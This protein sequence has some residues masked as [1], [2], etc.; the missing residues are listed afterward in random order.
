MQLQLVKTRGSTYL[1]R[2]KHRFPVKNADMTHYAFNI[3]RKAYP[4][5][6][7][8]CSS[9][10]GRARSQFFK[11]KR[12]GCGWESRVYEQSPVALALPP[13]RLK[14][15]VQIFNGIGVCSE[16][17]SLRSLLCQGRCYSRHFPLLE[18]QKNL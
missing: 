16:A 4:W 10:F 1:T 5:S 7:P 17:C 15:L 13:E 14:V 2:Q 12:F 11:A 3:K 9:G 18:V 8:F 6:F